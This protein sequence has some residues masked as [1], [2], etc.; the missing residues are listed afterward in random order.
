MVYTLHFFYLNFEGFISEL[1]IYLYLISLNVFLLV[2]F[3]SR[4]SVHNIPILQIKAA[5]ASFLHKKELAAIS[6]SF[7]SPKV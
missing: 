1:F 7:D 6:L 4:K 2:I 3:N 5:I